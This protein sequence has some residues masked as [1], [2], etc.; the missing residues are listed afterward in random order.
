VTIQISSVSM[1]Y[2]TRTGTVQ[3]LDSVDIEVPEAQFL[4]L[5]GPS[6]CGKSTLL[7]LTAGLLAASAGEIRIHGEPVRG[8]RTDVGFMFQTPVLLPWRSVLGNVLLQAKVRGLDMRTY[9]LRSRELLV[10]VGLAGYE[11]RYVFELSGGMQQRVAFCRAVLH[12]PSVLLM[13]EPF[14]ALD[15]LTREQVGFDLQRMWLA[16]GGQTVLFVTHSIAEAALL[17]DRIAVF[18][19]GP[20]RVL[21]VLDV[22]LARPRTAETMRSR[23]FGDLTAHVRGLI[24]S[25]NSGQPQ[26]TEESRAS[27]LEGRPAGIAGSDDRDR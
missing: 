8:P 5:V 16:Q 12:E 2:R 13:D 22:P 23:E 15:A 17:A 4:A 20:G 19:R 10:Q 25:P 1:T 14:G 3:A 21:D 7:K 11:D 18:S 6:G 9:G 24:M 27:G 26:V